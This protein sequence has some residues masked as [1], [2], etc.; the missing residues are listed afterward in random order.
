[1]ES[2]LLLLFSGI[3]RVLDGAALFYTTQLPTTLQVLRQY[4]L[5]LLFTPPALSPAMVSGTD[6]PAPI[7]NPFPFQNKPNTLDR[8]HIVIPA[9]WDSWGKISVMREFEPKMWGEAW[10]RDV[11]E[12]GPLEEMGAR[13]LY[14]ALVPDQGDKVSTVSPFLMKHQ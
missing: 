13:R 1:M 14:N 5:H 7:R 4:A 8:D 12:E 11:D 3:Y 9:G 6:A 2:A 10:D